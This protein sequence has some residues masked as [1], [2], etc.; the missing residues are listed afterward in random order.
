MSLLLLPLSVP[1]FAALN[2]KVDADRR[3]VVY[4]MYSFSGII[5]QVREEFYF[6]NINLL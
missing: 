3:C 4:S 6:I 2:S 1:A 5:S